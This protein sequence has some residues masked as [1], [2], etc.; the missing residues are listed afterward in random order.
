MIRRL[1]RFTGAD[2]TRKERESKLIRRWAEARS[3]R[4][5]GADSLL[6]G[7]FMRM[8]LDQSV[9][10][11][12]KALPARGTADVP[13]CRFDRSNAA[14]GTMPSS[15]PTASVNSQFRPGFSR[16]SRV[17]DEAFG[18]RPLHLLGQPHA[19]PE[20]SE[21]T[22]GR[23]PQLIAAFRTEHVALRR[24]TSPAERLRPTQRTCK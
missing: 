8:K 13:R 16:N 7:W 19:S 14:T 9:E 15:A 23:K 3:T 17:L 1:T 21:L 11:F 4:E 18:E 22:A 12:G 6:R 10:E 2:R 5:L 24:L 20:A